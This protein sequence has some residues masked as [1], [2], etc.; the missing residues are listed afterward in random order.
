PY[1]RFLLPQATQS[2]TEVM[3]GTIEGIGMEYF[4]LNDTLMVVGIITNGP[5]DKAGIKEGDKI[6][7]IDDRVLAGES[8]SQQEV[9]RLMRG[10]RGTAVE[11]YVQRDSVQLP[12]PLKAI[13]DQINVSSLDVAYMIEPTVGFIRLRRFSLKTA[14]EFSDAVIDLK[15][16]GATSLIFDLRDNGGGYFHIAIKLASEFFEDQC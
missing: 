16:Q 8:V 11:M 9:E 14:S 10:K 5:A 2:Q 15:K 1:S 6:L 7:K 13:R 12:L 4:S 3:E